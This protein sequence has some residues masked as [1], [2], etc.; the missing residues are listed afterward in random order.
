MQLIVNRNLYDL[1]NGWDVRLL[2]GDFSL[3]VLG[4][5]RTYTFRVLLR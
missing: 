3:I 2:V 1:K 5:E 4:S